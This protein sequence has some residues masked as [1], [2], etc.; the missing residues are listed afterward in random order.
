MLTFVWFYDGICVE[1]SVT[2]K[3][4]QQIA[5]RPGMIPNDSAIFNEGSGTVI[6]SPG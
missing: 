5:P 3:M 4:K 2:P 1:L 6:N